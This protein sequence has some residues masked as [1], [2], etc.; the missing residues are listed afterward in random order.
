M[1][2]DLHLHTRVYSGCSNIEPEDLVM[3]AIEIGLDGIALTEHGIR[4]SDEKVESL[5]LKT[6]VDDLVIVSGQEITCF[7]RKWRRQGDFLVFGVKESL[8]SNISAQDLIRVVHAEGGIVIP[9]HPY[10]KSRSRYD[11]YGVGDEMIQLDVDAIEYYHPEHD[12][13]ALQK[14]QEASRKM[15]GLPL[16]GGSDAHYIEMVGACTTI[17]H[18]P[19]RNERQLIDAIRAGRI[20]P[21]RGHEKAHP[22]PAHDRTQASP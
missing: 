15:G 5:H 14:V 8:G 2:F 7:T 18:E 1:V 12:E 19:V 22:H 11:L 9:A 4:W 10:K 21:Q 20:N 13:E 16:T 3:R 17:F 6:G